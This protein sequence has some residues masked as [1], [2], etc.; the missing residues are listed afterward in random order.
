MQ[1]VGA[2][3]VFD[4]VGERNFSPLNFVVHPEV[5]LDGGSCAGADMD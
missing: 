2:D 1:M 4:F 5:R 3:V